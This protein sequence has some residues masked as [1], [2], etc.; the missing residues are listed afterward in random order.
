MVTK[1]KVIVTGDIT[2]DWNLLRSRSAQFRDFLWEPDYQTKS[3]LVAGGAALLGELIHQAAQD[4]AALLRPELRK[5]DHT[6]GKPPFWHSYTICEQFPKTRTQP[7]KEPDFVWRVKEFLGLEQ[8]KVL[9]DPAESPRNLFEDDDG[10]SDIVVVDDANQ[11]FSK[12]S[13][14]WAKSLKSPQKKDGWLL[15]KW[16]RPNF[17]NPDA[18]WKH[19]IKHFQHRLIVV[20]T[21]NDLR[22]REIN[23]SRSL[24]WERTA[25]DL[26]REVTNRISGLSSCAH[27]VVALQTEGAFVV[28]FRGEGNNRQ[29]QATL[30]YDP[31]HIEGTWSAK[32]PGYMPGYTQCL[33]AGIALEMILSQDPGYATIS[34]GVRGGLA[35]A[36]TLHERGFLAHPDPSVGATL[37]E[38]DLQFP[39]AE[40]SARLSHVVRGGE[41]IEAP[42]PFQQQPVDTSTPPEAGGW[43]ILQQHYHR[44]GAD[45]D[46]TQLA[47]TI[48]QRGKRD[49]DWPVPI[50]RFDKLL[51]INREEIESLR[52]IKSLIQEYVRTPTHKVPLSIA[53]FGSPGT[54]KS[55]SVK[56]VAKSLEAE[57]RIKDLTF[58]LS[59]FS[60]PEPILSCLHQIRD[61]ALSE[62]MPL[63]FWDEFDSRLGNADFG[64]LRYFLAPMQDGTFQDGPLTHNIGR[65]IFVFAGGTTQTMDDFEKAAKPR[66]ANARVANNSETAHGN[67]GGQLSTP[68]PETKGTDFLSRLKGYVNIPKLDH[69]TEETSD[70]SVVIRRALLL[71]EKLLESTPNLVQYLKDGKILN[72]DPGVL[73]AFLHIQQYNYGAR[74]MEAIIKM[75]MLAGKSMFERSSLPTE[76]QLKLHVDAERFLELANAV[77]SPSTH[78]S[79]K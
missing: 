37:L 71:R 10:Q 62:N 21:A 26:L 68:G 78:P 74:S 69:R 16:A 9:T 23:I 38:T 6:P 4:D 44:G 3:C 8:T 45:G 5:T 31:Q 18:I 73:N 19:A 43:T 57:S 40:V 35:A 15:L 12:L 60:T 48:V 55:F 28:S 24:S 22:L 75:S 20:V 70:A 34:N 27:F 65:A 58:N 14:I 30:Y 72:V 33:V 11:G 2:L 46:V 66:Q 52:A 76:A 51:A 13:E 59:Q 64:W 41:D 25:T 42:V 36:R 7:D 56:A 49:E 50:G 61:L 39:V 63:V 53:V 67:A 17:D 29:R 79:E 1:K 54:G 47:K 77:T 32:Y